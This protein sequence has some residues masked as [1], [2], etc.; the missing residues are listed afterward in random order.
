[1]PKAREPDRLLADVIRAHYEARA[2]RRR[3]DEPSPPHLRLQDWQVVEQL[4]VDR[5]EYV[6]LRRVSS[7]RNGIDSLT[8]RER[9]AVRHAC[10]GASNKDIA[11]EMGISDSTVGVLLLRACRKLDAVDR[12]ALIRTFQSWLSG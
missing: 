8:Q 9:D 5:A 2:D 3:R 11:H 12:D 10:T 1:M 6:L 7:A 4:S